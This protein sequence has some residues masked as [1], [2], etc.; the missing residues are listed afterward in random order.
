[1]SPYRDR[2]GPR[3][4]C[5]EQRPPYRVRPSDSVVGALPGAASASQPLTQMMM[6]HGVRAVVPRAAFMIWAATRSRSRLR[7]RSGSV[8]IG[9]IVFPKLSVVRHAGRRGRRR[10]LWTLNT[11][12]IARSF[13]RSS[14]T[15]DGRGN[16]RQC[17]AVS[18]GV[19]A[20]RSGSR[21]WRR[22]GG[23]FSR[24][25]RMDLVCSLGVRRGHRSGGMGGVF[26]SALVGTIAS[27]WIDKFG[28]AAGSRAVVL[29]VVCADGESSSDKPDGPYGGGDGPGRAGGQARPR[30]SHRPNAR[31]KAG[32][33]V[34]LVGQVGQGVGWLG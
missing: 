26:E 9:D 23:R 25:C 1:M 20:A 2:G 32:G 5:L 21:R 10:L 16:G 28:K 13:A 22:D 6:N 19:F 31:V 27:A 3:S 17:V 14:T 30:S 24:V 12:L 4:L 8:E 15:R 33:S 11:T 18:G 29:H 7:R 34:G